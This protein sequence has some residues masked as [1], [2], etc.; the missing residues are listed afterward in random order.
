MCN[1][2]DENVGRG[3]PLRGGPIQ[4]RRRNGRA[5][6]PLVAPGASLPGGPPFPAGGRAGS[7][8]VVDEGPLPTGFEH[9]GPRS[10]PLRSLRHARVRGLLPLPRGVHPAGTRRRHGA[11]EVVLRDDCPSPFFFLFFFALIGNSLLGFSTQ[12][13]RI[14]EVRRPRSRGRP[15][16]RGPA[17]LEPRPGPNEVAVS[18]PPRPDCG[19]PV[20]ERHPGADQVLFRSGR[21][22]RAGWCLIDRAFPLTQRSFIRRGHPDYGS[23]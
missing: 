5:A 21:A 17:A 6:K 7:G 1:Q 12:T 11:D 13:D 10:R 22:E 14:E 9:A 4:A 16:G 15:R 19:K 18:N 20:E 8:S 23:G 3:L 2:Q